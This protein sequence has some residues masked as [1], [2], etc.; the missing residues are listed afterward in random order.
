MTEGNI[1]ILYFVGMSWLVWFICDWLCCCMS[2]V[3]FPANTTATK[4]H[5]GDKESRQ[6]SRC[7]LLLQA[8]GGNM[9][10]H[11]F[12]LCFLAK[13]R[14]SLGFFFWYG[15]ISVTHQVLEVLKWWICCCLVNTGCSTIGQLPLQLRNTSLPSFRASKVQRLIHGAIRGLL[16]DVV[17][18]WKMIVNIGTSWC[19]YNNL[20][21]VAT[22]EY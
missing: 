3:L 11:C 6:S 14:V 20:C 8:A 1:K 2:Y 15:D 13:G 19:E 12:R 10:F 4:S 18:T 9:K 7:F 5:W 17:W 22:H 21:V 16:Q